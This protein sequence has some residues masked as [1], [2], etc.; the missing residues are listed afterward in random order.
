MLLVICLEVLLTCTETGWYLIHQTELWLLNRR[1]IYSQEFLI[2][3]I[4][5]VALCGMKVSIITWLVLGIWISHKRLLHLGLLQ[6][7]LK[8]VGSVENKCSEEKLDLVLLPH[9]GHKYQLQLIHQA[10]ICFWIIYLIDFREILN[11][12]KLNMSHLNSSLQRSMI[13]L[14]WMWNGFWQHSQ[15]MC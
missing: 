15:V 8:Q 14:N 4:M 5:D 7:I 3:Q 1:L 12:K 13:T 2:D 10:S 9:L 6:L 11:L